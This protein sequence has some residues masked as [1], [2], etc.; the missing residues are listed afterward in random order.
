M[1]LALL[2]LW[3]P[4]NHPMRPAIEDLFN[5]EPLLAEP[6][7][8]STFGWKPTEDNT[9]KESLNADV[10]NKLGIGQKYMPYKHQ[11][12]S[13]KALAEGKSIVVTSG[14]GSGKTECF[15]YPVLSD[16][17]EQGHTN[18][19]EAIFLYPLN[20]LMEDQKKRLSE[21]CQATGLHFA[22]YNG[23]SPEYREDGRNQKLANE[24]V[25]R[26]EIRDTK[27]AGTRPEILLTNPSMLEYILVRQKDQQMLQASSGKLRWIVIDEAHSYSGSSAV[28]LAYQIKRILEAFGQKAEDVRFAC[29]SATIGGNEGT[30]S[31]A[32]FIATITGQPVE[33][34]QVIGGDRLVRPLDNDK[35]AD[36]LKEKNLPSSE[37]VLSLRD[38][39]NEVAGM[40]LQQMWEWLCPDMPYDNKNLLP[41]LR[42]L[43]DLCE[44]S[45]DKNPVLSLRAHFFM[46]AISGLYTC[47]NENCAGV[48]PAVP[49][50]GHLTTYKASVCPH[51]LQRFSDTYD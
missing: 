21:Y 18:A 31:L 34:I 41:A 35:L 15:M 42:L 28:E 45:Q 2:S 27:N 39:I 23:D 6:V 25:T 12:E 16:L 33:Q 30:Q 26:D 38:K 8:Q 44:I 13:W 1:R 19:I 47:A 10:I 7:F 51:W 9:W 11:A 48:N 40:T 46:R 14:T 29:T 50:Y 3:A 32:E 22:V 43:D 17:Y 4:G 20:A 49:M 36:V 5:R 37:K 24:V